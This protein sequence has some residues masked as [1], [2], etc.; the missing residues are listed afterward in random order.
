MPGFAR[1]RAVFPAIVARS[2][3]S[4]RMTP[5]LGVLLGVFTAKI[6]KNA[7]VY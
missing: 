4:L 7:K 1:K 5:F 3:A 2:F 6:A